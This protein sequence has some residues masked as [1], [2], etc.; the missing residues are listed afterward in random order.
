MMSTC[1]SWFAVKRFAERDKMALLVFPCFTLSAVLHLPFSVG[2]HLFM[3]M[4]EHTFNVWRRL[5]IMAIFNV[6]IL[7][8]FSLPYY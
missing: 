6:S 3:S 4:D 2:Y 1:A 5:D 8:T 7:L